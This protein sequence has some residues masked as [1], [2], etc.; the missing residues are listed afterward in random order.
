MDS[1]LYESFKRE[2]YNRLNDDGKRDLIIQTIRAIQKDNDLSEIDI[3]FREGLFGFDHKNKKIIIDLVSDDSYE[4]LTGIIHELRHQWQSEKGNVSALASYGYDYILSPHEAD[5]HEYAIEEMKKLQE[6]FNNDEFDMYLI[7][8]EEA[9]LSKRNSAIYQ[10]QRSGYYDVEDISKKMSLYK[11]QT[12]LFTA[13]E[14]EES[15]EP[16]SSMVT[17]DNGING[18][19]KV[20]KKNNNIFLQ[21]PGIRGVL[22]GTD[23]YISQIALHEEISTAQFANMIQL[24]MECLDELKDIDINAHCTQIHFPPAM[25]GLGG[26][27]KKEY[28]SFLKSLNCEEGIITVE[29][30]ENQNYDKN[31]VLRR[32]INM[33]PNGKE[34]AFGL[35]YLQE[36]TEEQIEVL[37]MAKEWEL[38]LDDLKHPEEETETSETPVIGFF[39]AHQYKKEYSPRKL[40]LI[41]AGQKRGLNTLYYE[42]LDEKQIEQLMILQLE[43]FK[44]EDWIKFMQ[45]GLNMAEIR[46]KLEERKDLTIINGINLDENCNII[47]QDNKPNPT[48]VDEEITSTN[49]GV[50]SALDISAAL[51]EISREGLADR[52]QSDLIDFVET[53]DS[54]VETQKN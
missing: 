10:Y 40:A 47:L 39:A 20:N 41:L 21:I 50:Y 44:R 35:N 12:A 8:L 36:Y 15:G 23:L 37:D 19:I 51:Q 17:F 18:I 22:I 9:Y 34:D 7:N 6:F 53:R 14:L 31:H 25:I 30:I 33:W 52:T 42:N 38:E 28:E 5:A 46:R 54:N 11:E 29:S 48:I 45:D 2:T 16:E 24:Y 43:G 27:E 32:T 1:R 49:Q 3:E 26:I 4:I 13:E